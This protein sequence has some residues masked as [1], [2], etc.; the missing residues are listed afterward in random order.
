MSRFARLRSAVRS[1]P[2]GVPDEEPRAPFPRRALRAA[3]ESARLSEA[4]WAGELRQIRARAT[5]NAFSAAGG[6]VP[7]ADP[8]EL[9]HPSRQV[10]A[11]ASNDRGEQ[12][13]CG[14]HHA[15][16]ASAFLWPG[17]VW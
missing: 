13:R 12:P 11:T 14:N 8:E 5:R 3:L 7:Q 15:C 16:C 9:P 17:L 10:E 2:I 6:L 1:G 4:G